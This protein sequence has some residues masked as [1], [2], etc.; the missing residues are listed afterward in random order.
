[1]KMVTLR[2]TYEELTNQYTD[3]KSTVLLRM[4]PG[5]LQNL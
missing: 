4:N 1:M 3:D 2:V 5:L